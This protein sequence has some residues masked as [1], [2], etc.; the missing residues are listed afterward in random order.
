[1]KVTAGPEEDVS[2]VVE[3]RVRGEGGEWEILGSETLDEEG[4]ARFVEL[5]E[6][7]GHGEKKEFVA[8]YL[9]NDNIKAGRTRVVGE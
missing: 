4:G 7:R 3:L 1:M 6:R 5:H 9:G 8:A 2:G